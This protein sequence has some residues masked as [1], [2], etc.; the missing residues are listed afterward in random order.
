MRFAAVVDVPRN[1]LDADGLPICLQ[2]GHG[3]RPAEHAVRVDDCLVH[4]RCLREA[5]AIPDPCTA[6]RDAPPR[7]RVA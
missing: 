5:L 4:G 1:Y 3:M 6:K 2:C 7:R